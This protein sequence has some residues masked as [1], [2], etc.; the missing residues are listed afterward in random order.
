MDSMISGNVLGYLVRD[1]DE[2][3]TIAAGDDA[4]EFQS[5]A[6]DAEEQ[7]ALDA[8]PEVGAALNAVAE[9]NISL[10]ESKIKA[11]EVAKMRGFFKGNSLPI[12]HS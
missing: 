5:A 11:A 7:E 4:D 9:A 12:N 3:S 8:D 2:S 10:R 6:D 1:E